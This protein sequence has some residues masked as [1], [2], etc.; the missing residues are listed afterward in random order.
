VLIKR[1]EQNVE[2]LQEVIDWFN[3]NIKQ[4]PTLNN[5]FSLPLSCF[6]FTYICGL[7]LAVEE[8]IFYHNRQSI[9]ILFVNIGFIIHKIGILIYIIKQTT[10]ISREASKTCKLVDEFCEPVRVTE[11]ENLFGKKVGENNLN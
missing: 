7:V 3:D 4:M 6:F 2:E 8:L 1:K 5:V 11:I 9:P 10:D